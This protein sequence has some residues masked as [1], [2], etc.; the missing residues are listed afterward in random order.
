VRPYIF[1]SD[2]LC[3]ITGCDE[4]I[5]AKTKKYL[6]HKNSQMKEEKEDSMI[7]LSPWNEK[8]KSLESKFTHKEQK[9]D[10]AE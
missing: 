2:N 4:D 3:T 10:V 5:V 6:G 1:N 9:L 7:A 8:I